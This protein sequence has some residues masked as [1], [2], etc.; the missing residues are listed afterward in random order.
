VLLSGALLGK[1]N[2]FLSQALYLLTGIAGLPVFSG[3]GSGLPRLLGPAGGYLLAFPV[4][5]FVVGY[6]LS[7]RSNLLW[8]VVSMS[9]G[10]GIIFSLGTVQL[11]V[12]YFH[13]WSAAIGSGLMIF[14]W[15]D[16]MKLAA[17]ATIATSILRRRNHLG[18]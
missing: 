6:L 3:F 13:D 14:S 11:Y 17:A 18:L 10:L 12:V 16:G 15:W 9:V 4:A 7:R 1:R 5:A 2:G 8:S